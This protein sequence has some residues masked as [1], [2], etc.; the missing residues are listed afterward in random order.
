MV[1]LPKTKKF[2]WLGRGDLTSLFKSCEIDKV[3]G[4]LSSNVGNKRSFT[5]RP[6]DLQKLC[7]SISLAYFQEY[8]KF[9]YDNIKSIF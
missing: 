4:D 7:L 9:I 1:N 5:S 3:R 2:G 8:S 6:S